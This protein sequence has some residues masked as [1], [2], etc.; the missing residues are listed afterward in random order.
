MIVQ[1]KTITALYINALRSARLILEM[2]GPTTLRVRNFMHQKPVN[3][4]T[5]ATVQEPLPD[6]AILW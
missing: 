3:F 5:F 6:P 4:R 2:N 1:P